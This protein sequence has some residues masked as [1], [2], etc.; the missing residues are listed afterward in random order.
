LV[1][2]NVCKFNLAFLAFLLLI[3]FVLATVVVSSVASEPPCIAADPAFAFRDVAHT[4]TAVTA[5][6]AGF[7]AAIDVIC[8]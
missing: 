2:G 1:H 6:Y 7:N 5:I 3:T 4:I 8:M